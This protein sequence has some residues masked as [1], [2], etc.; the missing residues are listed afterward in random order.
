MLNDMQKEYDTVKQKA[1]DLWDELTS[2]INELRKIVAQPSIGSTLN[3]INFLIQSEERQQQTGWQT[4][5]SALN[6]IKE[7]AELIANIEKGEKLYS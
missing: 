7:Y 1:K 5:C 2:V 4:R 6:E 3:Y